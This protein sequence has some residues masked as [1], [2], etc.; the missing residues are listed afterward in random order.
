V[1]VFGYSQGATVASL[2][3]KQIATLNGGL[4]PDDV[5]FVLI[6]N[7]NRPNGGL[8]ERLALLG[9]VPILDATFGQPTPT[10]TAPTGETNTTDIAFQYDGV[11]DF[12]AAPI[13][14][15]ADVNA[16]A[17][18][19]YVHGTYLDPRGRPP[20]T[21]PDGA[22]PYGY[23]A[24]EVEAI[25][26]GCQSAT[27]GPNCQQHGDTTYVTLPARS[28]P[29]MQPFIDLGTSTGTEQDRPKIRGPIGSD[30]H[31]VRDL[32]KSIKKALDKPNGIKK[33]LDKPNG[34]E[35]ALAHLAE[36]KKD[37]DTAHAATGT[38]G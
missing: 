13:N 34:I 30:F 22:L 35:K 2:F 33:A 5:S 9:T 27:P 37:K 31:P 1:V 18:F 23:T 7:P 21:T 38:D 8:F 20:A 17:G 11:A 24:D 16:A 10:D 15:L 36:Q 32:A 3:K 26:A 6:G 28:L 14:L 29:I 12:P 25:V 4:L 19:W